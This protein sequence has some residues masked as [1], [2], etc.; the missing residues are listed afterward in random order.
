MDGIIN[1]NKPS[2][3][4]SHSAVQKIRR[5]AGVK[6][7]HCGTLDPIASGVLILCL[8]KATRLSSF[9]TNDYK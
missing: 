7:G 4:T 1:L 3:I 8:G 9:F 6:V 5:R 2:G